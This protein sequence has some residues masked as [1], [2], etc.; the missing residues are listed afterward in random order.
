MKHS[1]IPDVLNLK[2]PVDSCFEKDENLLLTID[3]LMMHSQK[4]DTMDSKHQLCMKSM[5]SVIN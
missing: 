4:E 2:N 5:F 3:I 1:L